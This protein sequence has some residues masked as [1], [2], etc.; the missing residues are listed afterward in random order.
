MRHKIVQ[1]GLLLGGGLTVVNAANVAL[2]PQTGQTAT[3]PVNPAPADSDG[4]LQKGKAWP[5]TR[6]TLDTSGNCITDNLTGLMWVR[7]LNMVDSG[8]TFNWETALSNANSANWCGY[9][10]WRVPNINELR[11]LVNY[12]KSSPASWLNTA[13][14]SGGG[15]FSNVQ[16]ANYWS[17]SIYANNT[18]FVWRV[19]MNSGSVGAGGMGNNNV[20]IWLFPV[21][22][23]Q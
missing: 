7:D 5:T 15:G 9:D 21:R 19:N 16:S 14:A 13:M 8:N 20:D 1:L 3:V 11:S 12:G 23:G 22:G 17:S 18:A 4:A 2:V 10:D 6:F